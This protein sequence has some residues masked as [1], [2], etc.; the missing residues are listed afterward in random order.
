MLPILDV[1]SAVLL[2]AMRQSFA[3]TVPDNAHA[4]R[5]TTKRTCYL[6]LLHA[7]VRVVCED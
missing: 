5:T 7:C 1:A 3:F 4:G 2:G 6:F